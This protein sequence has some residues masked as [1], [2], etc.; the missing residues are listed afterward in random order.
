ML[1]ETNSIES[2]N[3]WRLVSLPAG[4]RPIGLKWVYKMKKNSAGEVVKHKER[5]VA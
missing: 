2:N 4:H 5:P 1:E 3:T